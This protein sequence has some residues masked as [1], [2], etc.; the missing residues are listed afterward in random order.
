MAAVW[1][2][3]FMAWTGNHGQKK[4]RRRHRPILENLDDRCLLST[5]AGIKLTEQLG[6]HALVRG[7]AAAR[8]RHDDVTRGHTPDHTRGHHS[9]RLR[10]VES[11]AGTIETGAQTAYDPIIGAAAVRSA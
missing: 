5:S 4:T 9:A 6:G 3:T 2:D 7:H 11:P 10:D 1:G 8:H